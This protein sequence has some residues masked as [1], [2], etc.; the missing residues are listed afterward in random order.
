[1]TYVGDKNRLEQLA[2]KGSRGKV[3]SE[4]L[5]TPSLTWEDQLEIEAIHE[6]LYPSPPVDEIS[7]ASRNTPMINFKRK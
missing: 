2:R 1:M 3:T 7:H 4:G 6:R 5:I